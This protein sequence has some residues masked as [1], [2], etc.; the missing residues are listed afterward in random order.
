M[1]HSSL[2]GNPQTSSHCA[3]WSARPSASTLYGV[4]T[5]RRVQRSRHSL[6]PLVLHA[7][8]SK[9]GQDPSPTPPSFDLGDGW[10]VDV[11]PSAPSPNTMSTVGDWEADLKAASAPSISAPGKKAKA[12]KAKAGKQTQ[13]QGHAAAIQGSGPSKM[14]KARTASDRAPYVS[15]NSEAG[16]LSL[17]LLKQKLLR[18]EGGQGLDVAGM[19]QQLAQAA[20]TAGEVTRQRNSGGRM[21]GPMDEEKAEGLRSAAEAAGLARKARRQKKR[22]FAEYDKRGALLRQACNPINFESSAEDEE[23]E[24]T[25]YADDD[26]DD[27]DFSGGGGWGALAR[28][29]KGRRAADSLDDDGDDDSMQGTSWRSKRLDA[30][31]R[32]GGLDDVLSARQVEALLGGEGAA[33]AGSLLGGQA[34]A[35]EED[36]WGLEE[37]TDRRSQSLMEQLGVVKPRKQSKSEEEVPSTADSSGGPQGEGTIGD[38][39][40]MVQWGGSGGFGSGVDLDEQEAILRRLFKPHKV[41]ELMSHQRAAIDASLNL[42]K[43]GSSGGRGG[44]FGA[45]AKLHRQ[46]RIIGGTAINRKLLSSQGSQTRPM[47][48]KVRAAIFSMIQ[49]QAGTASS[50]PAGSR[51]LDLFAGTGSV[52]LEAMWVRSGCV[53][54]QACIASSLPAGSRWLDLFAG[55][56]SVGLEAMSRGSEQAHFVELDPWVVRNVLGPNITTCGF[57]RQAVVHTTKAETFLQKARSVPR[58]AGGAFDFISVCPPYLLVSY[59]ELFKLLEGSPLLHDGTIMF[60]EY[61]RQL[62]SQIP[63]T[64]GSLSKVRD[65]KYGRTWVA[66]YAP[67]DEEDE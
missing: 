43:R 53:L 36:D 16:V 12:L 14:G 51:W 24:G 19:K 42:K 2:Q 58:F 52:G 6:L 28:T 44:K 32:D 50:L 18:E 3:F 31:S 20:T 64:L 39:V 47:M 5:G 1:K 23:D 17:E 56:G 55:T 10:G 67:D 59:P 38:D 9:P 48:E 60:V 7:A 40:G 63:D 26:E 65:R 34:Q 33:G 30:L 4:H 41:K 37:I 25:S 22:E 11:A 54:E 35:E 45:E 21:G 62:A 29:R 8:A 46:L 57:N 15:M 61:P 66:V 49:S 13:Q 27:L